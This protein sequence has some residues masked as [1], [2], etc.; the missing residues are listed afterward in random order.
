MP[1]WHWHCHHGVLNTF[2]VAGNPTKGSATRELTRRKPETRAGSYLWEFA[3][4]IAHGIPSS[5]LTFPLTC[6]DPRYRYERGCVVA[7]EAVVSVMPA[8]EESDNG[9]YVPECVRIG[10]EVPSKSILRCCGVRPDTER[11]LSVRCAIFFYTRYSSFT[12]RPDHGMRGY[13]NPGSL[14]AGF[15]TKY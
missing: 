15:L 4:M 12:A 11:M 14:P 3:K 10:S 1:G 2:C 13:K 6:V 9:E 5:I 7:D 8:V